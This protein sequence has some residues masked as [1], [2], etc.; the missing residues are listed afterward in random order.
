MTELLPEVRI[1]LLKDRIR[2]LEDAHRKFQR[3]F[4]RYEHRKYSDAHVLRPAVN[5]LALAFTNDAATEPREK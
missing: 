3:A 2:E 5:E 1:V 4:L